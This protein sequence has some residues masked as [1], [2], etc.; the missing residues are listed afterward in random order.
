MGGTPQGCP[1]SMMFIVSWYLPWCRYLAAHGGGGG[2]GVSLNC[3]LIILSESS[4]ILTYSCVL[5][6]LPPAMFGWLARSLLQVS[7]SVGTRGIGCCPKRGISGLSSL[8]SGIWV[9]IQILP[10]VDC[11]Q[12]LAAR[13]RLVIARL[14]LIFALSL[15]VH[16]RIR[17][18]RSTYLPA[19]LQ[20]IGA[21]LLAS[22]SLRKL[23]SSIHR[24]VWSRRQP[25][26]SVGAVLGLLDGRTGCDP[27]FLR[28]LVSVSFAS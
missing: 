20:G 18:V 10:F 19:A 9:V 14:I 15:N 22:D 5:L 23:R 21:S 7:V 2:S 11:L 27:A 24:V 1:L 8:M 17:V 26:A 28:G 25:L 13:V 12:L 4:G 16:G 6:G 3:V